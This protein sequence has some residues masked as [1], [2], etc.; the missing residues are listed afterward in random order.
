MSKHN[1]VSVYMLKTKDAKCDLN[2]FDQS[3]CYLDEALSTAVPGY[4]KIK[5]GTMFLREKMLSSPC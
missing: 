5:S 2:I 4:N 1:K 3:L